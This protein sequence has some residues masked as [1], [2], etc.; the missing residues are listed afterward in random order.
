[1]NKKTFQSL[2][3]GVV[4]GVAVVVGVAA[5]SE[6][7]APTKWEYLVIDKN[8]LSKR[9]PGTYSEILQKVANEYGAEGWEVVGYS[10]T[11]DF[12]AT[13]MLKRARK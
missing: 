9:G 11:P 2:M 6:S 12:V 5:V 13:A 1:M 8:Q 10:V 3:A 7:S 4:L